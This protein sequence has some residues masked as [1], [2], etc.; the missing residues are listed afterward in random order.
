MKQCDGGVRAVSDAEHVNVRAGVCLPKDV[1]HAE[2]MQWSG[3]LEIP[4][5][6]V[7]HRVSLKAQGRLAG[8]R[9]C[10]RLLGA[11]VCGVQSRPRPRSTAA[12]QRSRQNAAVNSAPGESSGVA[13][14]TSRSVSCIPCRQVLPR[15]M[16][17]ATRSCRFGGPPHHCPGKRSIQ[18]NNCLQA[19]SAR[20]GTMVAGGCSCK[21]AVEA[22]V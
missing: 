21:G 14:A 17:A 22:Q 12:S 15:Q 18:S 5:L 11:W 4:R 9:G 6:S 20:E 3:P 13:C 2:E 8:N 19:C 7:P 16:W 10:E 1:L